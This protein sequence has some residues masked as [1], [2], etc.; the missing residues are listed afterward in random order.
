MPEVGTVDKARES[1]DYENYNEEWK[2]A[3]ETTKDY[4]A[5]LF[6]LRKY[7]F[8]ILT[9]LITAGSFLGS[10]TS[11]Q[12][13]QIGVIIVTMILVVILYWLDAY[14]SSL[15]S[16]PI[17][18]ARFLEAFKLNRALRLYTQNIYVKS[19]LA[20]TLR[21]LYFGF[22][23][24]LFVLGIFALG[25]AEFKINQLNVANITNAKTTN[26]NLNITNPIFT[27]KQQAILVIS[28][29]LIVAFIFSLAGIIV[30]YV[31]VDRH[32][33][34][35]VKKINKMF[36]ECWS[37]IKDK[38]ADDPQRLST[39]KELEDKLIQDEIKRL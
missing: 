34:N 31:L 5:I 17:L 6:D 4:D 15:I 14:Y 22:L 18:R 21:S 36:S 23:A 16:G 7:G 1:A 32:R 28:S 33:Q 30:I 20:W 38:K 10:S 39:I 12:I 27:S 29:P 24:G 13:L 35:T 19:H 26:P 9:G 37:K 2:V 25:I 8:S 11:T 3:M